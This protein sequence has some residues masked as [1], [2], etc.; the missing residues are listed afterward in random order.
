MPQLH[1]TTSLAVGG[2]GTIYTIISG[3]A[4]EW[5]PSS[6]P[7]FANLV[8]DSP[9]GLATTDARATG[10]GLSA[11]HVVPVASTI[12]ADPFDG[13]PRL[14]GYQDFAPYLAV[15]FSNSAPTVNLAAGLTQVEY[16]VTLDVGDTVIV[17]VPGAQQVDG[18]IQV[19]FLGFTTNP[20][21][22]SHPLLASYKPGSRRSP[23]TR[24][25]STSSNSTWPPRSRPRRRGPT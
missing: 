1:G 18:T 23:A 15:P 7:Q 16:Q 17:E 22:G 21:D 12:P 14:P 13:V 10:T 24:R 20:A 9:F 3:A 2:D 4:Y 11:T 6:Y 8:P 25:S 19:D 5:V